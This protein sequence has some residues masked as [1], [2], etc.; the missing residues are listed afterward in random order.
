MLPTEAWRKLLTYHP[1][2]YWWCNV[3]PVFRLRTQLQGRCDLMEMIQH[4][5]IEHT[6]RHHS[7][8]DDVRNL[9]AI[10]RQ[11]DI[12]DM[13]L[14]CHN[15]GVRPRANSLSCMMA[16]GYNASTRGYSTSPRECVPEEMPTPFA[17]PI[18][19]SPPQGSQGAEDAIGSSRNPP[20]ANSYGADI[21]PSRQRRRLEFAPTASGFPA[22]RSEA[23]LQ[24]PHN[25]PP[26]ECQLTSPAT[27]DE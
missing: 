19:L 15:G 22:I 7:G 4:L 14:I 25:A 16:M 24:S 21:F 23:A 6:G 1:S 9:I 2:L 10:I 13:S 17:R 27:P 3:K 8:I 20:R 12:R 18:R 26:E 5:Q 11:M